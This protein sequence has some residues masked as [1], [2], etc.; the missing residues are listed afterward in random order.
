MSGT[1]NFVIVG[2]TSGIGLET[3]KLY[4]SRGH[5]VVITGRDA[6]RS[7]KIASEI[8]DRATGIAV[9]L[10]EPEQIAA[11][12]ASIDRCDG[13]V[14]C[15][16]ERDANT[17]RNYDVG[18]AK[19]LV[20]LKL[21][22]YTECIHALLPKMSDDCS[23]VLFGG[24]AK[25]RPYPGSTT[26]TSVNGGVNN[27]IRTFATELAPIRFN[28]IHPG[29]IGDSPAWKDNKAALEATAARTPGGVLA[30]TKDVVGAV[31]FLLSNQ[32]INGVNLYVDRGWVLT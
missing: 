16:I 31:D 5:R 23:I 9:D 11:A 26:V 4:H 7:K 15:A 29:I 20:V 10:A 27:M 13:L 2:G 1:K 12:F 14:I 30:T 17:V 24:L 32:S 8:G 18:R 21:V 6:D 28:A 22:G 19:R 3:A 25:E